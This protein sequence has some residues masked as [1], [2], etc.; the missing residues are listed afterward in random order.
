MLLP[1][2]KKRLSRHGKEVKR[3][4]ASLRVKASTVHVEFALVRMLPQ[5]HMPGS[6]SHNVQ[7]GSLTFPSLFPR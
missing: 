1:H 2:L 3:D 7:Q 4:S 5:A 6:V